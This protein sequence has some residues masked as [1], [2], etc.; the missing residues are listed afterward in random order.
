MSND[1]VTALLAKYLEGKCDKEERDQLFSQLDT[2]EPKQLDDL[3]NSAWKD[4][5]S[6]ME[7]SE[8]DSR[9]I[10]N[11]ILAKRSKYSL[12]Y[13]SIAASILIGIVTVTYLLLAPKRTTNTQN[14]AYT[15]IRPGGNKAELLMANG[16]KILLGSGFQKIEM[17]N[18]GLIVQQHANGSLTYT[19]GI[20]TSPAKIA[21]DTLRTPKGGVYQV[22]LS[23][24]TKI[25]LN[26]FSAI[27]FPEKF[28][29]N[30]RD[31]ELLYG[32]A[33]FEVKHM[34]DAP[35]AVKT[36]AGIVR[37]LGTSFNVNSIANNGHVAATLLE[38]AIQVES[39]GQLKKVKPGQQAL[40]SKNKISVNDVDVEEMTAWKD[41]YFMFDESMESAMNKIALWYDV[42]VEY[43]NE[44]LKQIP[45]LATIT[46]YGEIKNVLR[47]LEMTK[48][49]RFNVNG[50]TIKV[51]RFTP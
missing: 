42:K 51:V 35:F 24:G 29:R 31:V 41:G 40:F 25:W 15:G 8:G 45:V 28:A 26:A 27:R 16:K 37:D 6:D 3:L 17:P 1:T 19:R 12:K 23:D 48:K 14:M 11:A 21:Y 39:N 33:Y 50:R 36:A 22:N 46:R 32:E 5:E 44:T 47:I 49:V 7:L 10:L 2:L 38:G 20:N 18:T 13:I 30:R 4:Y 43:Q 34:T 9:E